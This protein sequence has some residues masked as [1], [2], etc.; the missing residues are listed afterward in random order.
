M[1]PSVSFAAALT[2]QQATSLIT[3]VQSS[4]TTPASAFVSLITAFSNI[5]VNQATSLITVVQASPGTPASAFVDL[6]TSFTVDTSAPLP[7]PV[8][9]VP[10]TRPDTSGSPYT[11]SNLGYDLSFT[12]Y[13]YPQIGF[14]FAVVGVTRGKAFAYNERTRSEY[15]FA[16]FGSTRPTLY[17][18]L[19]AP[20]GSTATSTNM[21]TPRA[22]ARSLARPP[23]LLPLEVRIQ[24]RPSVRA[25]TMGTTQQ[26]MRMRIRQV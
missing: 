9:V 12:T 22:C 8:P 16:Q 20:Y 3:V 26:R 1:L 5:T 23:H 11:S 15:S 7:A 10:L 19:N 24:S 17:L 13:D 6:L 4:P 2:S 14:G 21:D 18:N 25:I